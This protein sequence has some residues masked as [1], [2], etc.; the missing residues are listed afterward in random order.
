MVGTKITSQGKTRS[1]SRSRVADR[2]VEE[3]NRWSGL[4]EATA[5]V[6]VRAESVRKCSRILIV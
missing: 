3:I 2:T 1:E 6:V 4:R 5:S